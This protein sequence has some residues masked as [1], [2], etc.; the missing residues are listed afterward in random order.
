[1]HAGR[2]LTYLDDQRKAI[3]ALIDQL[4]EI[5]VAFNAQY[6][7]FS[8]QHDAQLAQLA[9]RI[10]TDLAAV[11]PELRTTIENRLPEEEARIDERRRTIQ[12][13]YLPQRQQA[14]D[15]LLT[16]AQRELAALRA[17]NPKLDVQEEELKREGAALEAQLAGLNEEIQNKSRGLGVVLNFLT[18]T[19]ADRERHQI[20]GK[21]ELVN[22]SLRE[23]R[24]E[25]EQKREDTEKSQAAL[26]QRW[27]LESVA[28]A[29]LQAELDQLDDDLL[30]QD[31]ALR[32]AVRY[33]LDSLKQPPPCSSPDLEDSLQRMSTLNVRTDDFHTGLASV[34]GMI[35]LL[36]GIRSGLEAIQESVEGLMREQQMHS[37]YLKPLDFALPDH[38]LA[39]HQ[40]WPA[41]A[42]RFAD[43]ETIGTHPSDFAAS[44]QPLLEGP[45]AQTAIENMFTSLGAMIERAT[46]TW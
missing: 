7:E 32:R 41:L 26:R 14:A 37:A 6:D 43:E 2:I 35:G 12:E 27:Q 19:R 31:L 16:Q 13:T 46:A 24:R 21:L 22:R 42:E 11:G 4:D 36:R 15:E 20:L 38:V 3:Q 28:V 44:I 34:G 18:I 1:M 17:L 5:Q 8:A 25:W 9:D 40:Q 30:R 23:V 45:L 29:R 10:A 33:V 39:F